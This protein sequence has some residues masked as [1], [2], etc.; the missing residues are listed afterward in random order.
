[1]AKDGHIGYNN[2]LM[3]L[4]IFFTDRASYSLLLTT[5]I[6]ILLSLSLLGIYWRYRRNASQ[7]AT[8][9]FILEWAFALYLLAFLW[10]DVLTEL[11][12]G[13]L[14][15]TY[16]LGTLPETVLK[17]IAKIVFIPY[18]LTHI[19]ITVT[20]ILSFFA[21]LADLII[22]P[23]LFIPFILIATLGLYGL[24]LWQLNDKLRNQVLSLAKE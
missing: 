12:F 19:W 1:M 13:I 6:K 2:S 10:L 8:S 20:G 16:L 14:V 3:Q 24:I 11:T 4:V 5:V 22:D 15:F 23:S 18:A 17:N 7:K 21:P 9:D